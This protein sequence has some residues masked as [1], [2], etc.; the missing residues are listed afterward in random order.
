MKP[1]K[2]EK[3]H[4]SFCR[5]GERVALARRRRE[6]GSVTRRDGGTVSYS[7]DGARLRTDRTTGEAAA[8]S[9]RVRSTVGPGRRV[10]DKT[11]SNE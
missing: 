11:G 4:F 6:P 1:L 2:P 3:R 10:T 5:A 9:T 8:Q 7:F